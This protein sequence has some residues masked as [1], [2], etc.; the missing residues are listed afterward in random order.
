MKLRHGFSLS[1]VFACIVQK[2]FFYLFLRTFIDFSFCF[3][4]I[5]IFQSELTHLDLSTARDIRAL[6]RI[7]PA[8]STYVMHAPFLL[9]C[10]QVTANILIKNHND[11]S[12]DN[13]YSRNIIIIIVMITINMRIMTIIIT[14]TKMMINQ[15]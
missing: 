9:L 2:L 4:F 11:D 7:P 8:V 15:L 6:R 1:P 10:F 5:V 3:I 13:D 12:N 14:I